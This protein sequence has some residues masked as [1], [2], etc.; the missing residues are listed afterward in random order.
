M[1]RLKLAAALAVAA[2]TSIGLVCVSGLAQE[3]PAKLKVLILSGANNH[4]WKATTPA[5]KQILEDSGRFECEVTEKPA[6]CNLETFKKYDVV[7]S[8]YNGPRWGEA[9]EQGLLEYVR[10]G[11]GFVVV[12]AANNAFSNWPE[13]EV[14][15]GVA[16]R[17]GAGHGN[18][19][20][21]AVKI[22]NPDHPITQG[23]KDFQH[24]VDEL[25]H[26]LKRAEN[27]NILAVAHSDPAQRGT[28]EDEPMLV[29]VDYG[30]G[31]VFQTVMGHDVNAHGVGFKCTLLRGTEWAATG[32]V[33]IPIPED[34]PAPGTVLPGAVKPPAPPAGPL[35][36]AIKQWQ[37]IGPW[38]ND[39]GAA[40]DQTFPP[41]EAV[42]L[43]ATYKL[44][45]GGEEKD[46]GWKSIT[47][48][49]DGRLNLETAV[50]RLDNVCAFAYAEVTVAEAK[51]VLLKLGS[52]DGVVVYLNGQK[53][54]A[55]NATRG[56]KPDQDVV[57]TRLEAGTNR[58]L[59]K[60]LQGKG[61]WALVARITDRDGK[62]LQFETRGEQ[63]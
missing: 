23:M 56:L 7:L 55:N 19:H 15:I 51:D 1:I 9:A 36:G 29:T 31:R 40:F 24:N 34:W 41:E 8:D 49:D 61:Q 63:P 50:G 18:R 3:P 33:T 45:I 13:Y 21:F 17:Q 43:N 60:I 28:G 27:V 52:D 14:L 47:T 16:W 11:G 5:L 39:K 26:R 46:V 22:V 42:D 59:F 58:L 62:P 57:Q 4:N 6:E 2:A 37:V 20:S 12:H 35:E 44:S 54:H 10:G 53:I 30:Q 32:K 48:G 25:Y 38:S